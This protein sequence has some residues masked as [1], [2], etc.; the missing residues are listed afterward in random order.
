MTF[1]RVFCL[2]LVVT[3]LCAAPAASPAPAPSLRPVASLALVKRDTEGLSP[4]RFTCD[5]S[6]IYA[7]QD[8]GC[9]VSNPALRFS[10]KF[11]SESQVQ[12]QIKIGKV[13]VGTL[14]LLRRRCP[15]QDC[16]CNCKCNSQPIGI[17]AFKMQDLTVSLGLPTSTASLVVI[18]D[19]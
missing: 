10:D 8:T 9:Q 13:R 3:P 16:I 18:N 17:I 11:E 4:S 12:S 15:N 7:D 14:R 1:L 2:F 19:Q 5:K 6:G